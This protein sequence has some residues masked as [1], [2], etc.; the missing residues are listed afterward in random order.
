MTDTDRNRSNNIVEKSFRSDVLRITFFLS[1]SQSAS[2]LAH[3]CSLIETE[4]VDEDIDRRR[5][6]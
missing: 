1:S 5:R 6:A 2:K 3:S 4:Q